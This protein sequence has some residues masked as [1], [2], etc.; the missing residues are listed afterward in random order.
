MITTS[1]YFK[2][3]R[4]IHMIL[5][6]G[7]LLSITIAVIL[8]QLAVVEPSDDFGFSLLILSLIFG[9]WGIFGSQF[10]FNGIIKKGLQEDGLS[11]KLA[12]YRGATL[13]RG[14]SIE[15]AAIFGAVAC[16][17]SGSL[18][19]LGIAA[20]CTAYLAT[21]KPDKDKL[22]KILELSPSEAMKLDQDDAEVMNP[23]DLKEHHKGRY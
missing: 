17:L 15:G 23:E 3:S 12:T 21:L 16:V 1:E 13:L 6:G 10:L 14:A 7:A 11:S 2:L 20:I 5:M 19:P 8:S 18:I 22:K 4:L 9:L